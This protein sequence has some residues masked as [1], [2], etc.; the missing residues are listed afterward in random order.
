MNKQQKILNIALEAIHN[1]AKALLNNSWDTDAPI[2]ISELREEH[3][4]FIALH[5]LRNKVFTNYAV[6]ELP[7]SYID[8]K[9]FT[10]SDRAD[11]YCCD[12]SLDL[13]GEV[14][15]GG[16]DR[17]DLSTPKVFF[18]NVLWDLRKLKAMEIT[19]NCKRMQIII[20]DQPF[21]D[22]N[23]VTCINKNAYKDIH[24]W[25]EMGWNTKGKRIEKLSQSL[26][27]RGPDIS[28]VFEAYNTIIHKTI[29][30]SVA[31][32]IRKII[33]CKSD[34]ANNRELFI[35]AVIF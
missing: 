35:S 26:L 13:V 8:D 1:E 25:L 23:T 30:N 14:K 27:N 9:N 11:F 24:E 6:V 17:S 16:S 22:S 32:S 5:E 31:R 15:F 28:S 3:L 2:G 10:F 21:T 4:T 19:D 29:P 7:Y 33:K 34:R 20:W 12:S 18:M